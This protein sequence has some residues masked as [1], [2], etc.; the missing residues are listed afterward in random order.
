MSP[1]A[2]WLAGPDE[3]VLL[4]ARVKGAP[5]EAVPVWG[6]VGERVSSGEALP[7]TTIDEEGSL[8]ALP[9]LAPGDDRIRAHTHYPAT[10]TCGSD[11]LVHID[12]PPAST[13]P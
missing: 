4:R 9:V 2:V 5:G 3:R 1:P 7:V 8:A 12:A 6:W 10:E 13:S 11:L